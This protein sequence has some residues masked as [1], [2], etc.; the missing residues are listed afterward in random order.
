MTGTLQIDD[1]QRRARLV[2]RHL[3][4]APEPTDAESVT[5]AVV[6]L[7]ATDPATVHLSA[8][9]RG[10]VG[11]PLDGP[12][13]TALYERGSLVRLLAMRRTMFV[14][15]TADAGM[16]HAAA[17]RA[18]AAKERTKLLKVLADNDVG[19]PEPE[20]FV[21]DLEAATVE[22]LAG[23]GSAY[24]RDLGAAVPGLRQRLVIADGETTLATRI[25]LLLSAEGRIVRG[26][27]RGIWT[28]TQY[29][30]TLPPQPLP[31]E[32]ELPTTEARPLLAEA[33]LRAYGPATAADLQ[34]WTGWTGG[35]TKQALAALGAQGSV[36]AVPV[37]LADGSAAYVLEDDTSNASAVAPA[38]ALL[39]ALDPTVMGWTGRDFYLAPELRDHTRS[40]ALF[41]R[42]G[43]PGPTIWWGGRIVGGWAQRPDGSVATRL[44]S[45]GPNQE[46]PK[47]AT[48]AIAVAADGLAKRLGPLR[49][50]PR[51]RTALERS[52]AGGATG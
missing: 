21:A 46:M 47:A 32:Q 17:G 43:N 14:V 19:G 39:P 48:A 31:G 9:A 35:Q 27:P 42:S 7:H 5:A 11:D 25:L 38:V 52:L 49:V 10:A 22:A 20:E 51:F 4:T 23:L 26:R 29:A 13:N 1:D 40:D 50:T 37:E 12:V 33:Y 16:V 30:W 24:G 28:S 44:L 2:A 15:P 6:A 41:D 18:V 36:G 34:W 3:L 8:A 45:A